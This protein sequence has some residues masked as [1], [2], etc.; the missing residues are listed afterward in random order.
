[1]KFTGLILWLVLGASPLYAQDYAVE[2]LDHSPRH[3]EWVT[4]PSGDRSLR[5]FVAYPEKA[6]HT[7]AVIV[8]HENRGLTDW[9]RSLAD[10]LAAAGYVAIAPDLLSDVD[11]G[12]RQTRDF[13]NADDAREAIYHLNP[14][15]IT[16][17]LMAV[18]KYIAQVPSS[19]GKI[20]VIGFCWGGS[21]AFRFATNSSIIS[22]SLVFYGSAPA[23][24]QIRRIAAPVYGFYGR[25]DQRITATVPETAAL[26][27]KH[28]KVYQPEIYEGAGH[29]FMRDGDD[30]KGSPESKKA[31]D[32]AWDRIKQILSTIR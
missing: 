30:P 9:V 10:Q 27:K 2:Q 28:D 29:A 24:E 3:H 11:A 13:K 32:A 16:G 19:N 12:H 7:L 6:Q 17:D 25:N 5:S 31:R 15:R 18:Q 26:M 14:D 22:A 21:E 23:A 4:I 20:A 1:M 8:I